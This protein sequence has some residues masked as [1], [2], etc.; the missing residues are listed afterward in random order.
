MYERG[1][2]GFVGHNNDDDLIIAM[3]MM[4]MI[5]IVHPLPCLCE[6]SIDGFKGDASVFPVKW[7]RGPAEDVVGMVE[8]AGNGDDKKSVEKNHLGFWSPC[9]LGAKCIQD[10]KNPDK[11]LNPLLMFYKHEKKGN[12]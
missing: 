6:S 3:M 11:F 5:T 1:I 9:T 7:H 2:V 12:L 10:T 4:R 8:Q